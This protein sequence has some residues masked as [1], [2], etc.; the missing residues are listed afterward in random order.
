V[1]RTLSVIVLAL[2]LPLIAVQAQASPIAFSSSG[3]LPTTP[4]PVPG[5]SFSE[6]GL[7]GTL[8]LVSGVSSTQTI[9][10]A[11][12]DIGAGAPFQVGGFDLSFLFTLGGVTNMLTQHAVWGSS[13][14]GNAVLSFEASGPVQFGSFNVALDAFALW[15]GLS[16][17]VTAP[18]MAD[19][20]PASAAPVPEPASI[21]LLATGLVGAGVGRWRKRRLNAVQ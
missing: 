12:L 16:S 19:F 8:N 5:G 20:T 7:G 10:T 15:G 14:F 13:P 1:K 18:V 3:L 17:S 4:L 2:A 9:N 6:L 21:I 11:R